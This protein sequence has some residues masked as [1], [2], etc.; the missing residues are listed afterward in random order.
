[1]CVAGRVWMHWLGGNSLGQAP[2]RQ[3]LV[4]AGLAAALCFAGLAGL[5]LAEK[6]T[7]NS[8]EVTLERERLQQAIATQ[9]ACMTEA[10][11]RAVPATLGEAAAQAL[12]PSCPVSEGAPFDQL[13]RG[14]DAAGQLISGQGDVGYNSLAP[15]VAAARGKAAASHANALRGSMGIAAAASP[16]AGLKSVAFV[17]AEPSRHLIVCALELPPAARTGDAQGTG[18]PQLLVGVRQLRGGLLHDLAA[19]A[20]VDALHI[21]TSA[22]AAI[23]VLALE[24]PTPGRADAVLAWTAR[25]PGDAF[26]GNAG[27]GLGLLAA[28]LAGI[29]A[30]VLRRALTVPDV[31]QAAAQILAPATELPL[32]LPPV[33]RDTHSADL[34]QALVGK[35][36]QVHYLP[37]LCASGT[38]L[39]GVEAQ[40][41]W[42]HKERGLLRGEQVFSP[43]RDAGLAVPLGQFLMRRALGDAQGFPGLRLSLPILPGHFR[44]RDFVSY[45]R[46]CLTETG[47]APGQLECV[48]PQA[49]IGSDLDAAAGVMAELRA[50]GV[51]LA[52]ADLGKGLAG[53]LALRDLPFTRLKVC[54]ATLQDFGDKGEHALHAAAL[55]LFSGSLGLGISACG[56]ATAAQQQFSR[57]AGCQDLRGPHFSGAQPADVITRLAGHA[58]EVAGAARQAA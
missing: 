2:L 21:G 50:L 43:E 9:F 54:A 35:T 6:I 32:P 34:A 10:L 38:R 37:V 27:I 41:C 11:E 22:D 45:L 14:D 12:V 24:S 3:N 57:L 53:L 55:V 20:Q 5:V 30:L 7:R 8:A 29:F 36:L 42:Q 44:H 40:L 16:L 46:R 58:A 39:I 1:M 31:A 33:Q 18:K 15:F 51:A 49:A 17:T 13:F 26:A 47:F 4:A 48:V 25:R 52:L 23:G 19:A 28:L 56:V